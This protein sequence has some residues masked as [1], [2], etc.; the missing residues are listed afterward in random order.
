[1]PRNLVTNTIMS[2]QRQ[3]FLEKTLFVRKN[4]RHELRENADKL[5][6]KM[7]NIYFENEEDKANSPAFKAALQRQ[8]GG[9]VGMM[10]TVGKKD[11]EGPKDGI[12][13]LMAQMRP[14]EA[15]SHNI[16]EML[17]SNQGLDHLSDQYFGS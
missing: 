15:D 4:I 3:E 1:M 14:S 12:E 13:S 2:L 5:Q 10:M 8:S 11:E 7:E 6:R 9:L 17:D 16:V